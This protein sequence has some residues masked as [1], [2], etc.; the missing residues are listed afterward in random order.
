MRHLRTMSDLANEEIMALIEEA[1]EFQ[2]GKQWTPEKQTFVANLF[3]ESSTRTKCSFEVAERRLGLQVLPFEV[4]TSSVNKGESLYDT[5]KTLESLGVSALVIRHPEEEYFNQL[6]T[7]GAAIING[8]DGCGNHPTQSLLDLMTI[9]QEFEHFGKLKITIIGDIRHSRV[10]RSNAEVLERLGAKV[11]FVAPD[12]WKD[13]SYPK[14]AYITMEDAIQTSDV[15]MLL[16]IQH[17]RHH[18]GK[19]GLDAYH[20]EYG[21]TIQR[22]KEM[23]PNSIIMHPAPINRGVEIASELVECERSRIFKQME[24]GLYMRM[25]VL[26]RALTNNEG[27]KEHDN[28]IKEWEMA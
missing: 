20:Q 16:R 26:K 3:Y 2:Q 24:N 11:R 22:E 21:M 28:I 25:A 4:S 12:E 14:E 13:N 1:I 23:K 19:T 15:V 6:H 10:A 8:G 27:G 18:S 5:A 7:I 9:F 17:E